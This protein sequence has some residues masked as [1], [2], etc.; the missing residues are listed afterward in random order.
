MKSVKTVL[1]EAAVVGILL[2]VFVYIV[3]WA[4]HIAGYPMK[5]LDKLCAG[6]NDTYI[7][8]ITLFLSGV[9][10]HLVCEYTGINEWYVKNYYK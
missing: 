6:W 9:L 8:E 2:I 1:I 3:G 10:F 5:S 7:M 4:L